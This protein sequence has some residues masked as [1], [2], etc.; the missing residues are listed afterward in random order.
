MIYK[1][2]YD[3]A[4]DQCVFI[5]AVEKVSGTVVDSS[6]KKGRVEGK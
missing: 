6:I 1:P 2:Y 5:D 4:E 3:V